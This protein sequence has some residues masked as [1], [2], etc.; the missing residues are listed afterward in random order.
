[1]G[2]IRHLQKAADAFN[3]Q[4]YESKIVNEV[5]KKLETRHSVVT[6]EL[7]T[8]AQR[9]QAD[10]QYQRAE[11][12]YRKLASRFV[13]PTYK[14]STVPENYGTAL[15][16]VYESLGDFPAAEV[17]QHRHLTILTQQDTSNFDEE[18]IHEARK[19][20]Q[21]F[22]FFQGRVRELD[23]RSSFGLRN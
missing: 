4:D 20:A 18:I 2:D 8:R 11:Y 22:S 15:T 23:P 19:M 1:M 6:A 21:L 16:S 3:L 5:I 9:H 7:R 13:C 10:N 12:I 14:D 17:V